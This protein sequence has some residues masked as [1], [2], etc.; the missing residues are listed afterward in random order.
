MTVDRTSKLVHARLYPKAQREQ[1]AEFLE[2]VLQQLPY[3]VHTLLTN[4]GSQFVKRPGAESYKPHRFDVVC[5]RND[6]EHRLTCPFHP[7]SNRQIELMNRPIKEATIRRFHYASL[8]ELSAYL[9]DYLWAYNN[10]HPLRALKG[11]AHWIHSRTL[12]G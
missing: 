9:K 8:G 6:I 5:Y 11:N 12:A 3:R 7:W 1:T 10:A 2:D 4:N